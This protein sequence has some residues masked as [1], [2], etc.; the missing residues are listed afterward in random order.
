[1]IIGIAEKTWSKLTDDQKKIVEK[2]AKDAT[3]WQRKL[4]PE[5]T[6][7]MY[8]ILEEKGMT[9]LDIDKSKLV[10]ATRPFSEQW[11]KENGVEDIYK[12]IISQ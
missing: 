7:K 5:K 9:V 1:L 4:V 11:S 2:A 3:E 8:K 10:E 6:E 12:S